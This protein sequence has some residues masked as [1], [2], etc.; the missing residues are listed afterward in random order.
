MKSHMYYVFQIHCPGC[1]SIYHVP[2]YD[3]TVRFDF[4]PSIHYL[5]PV[6]QRGDA[7]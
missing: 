2:K 3:I 1:S 6:L 5:G 7:I 4:L